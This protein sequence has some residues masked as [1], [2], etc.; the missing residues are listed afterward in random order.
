MPNSY[1]VTYKMPTNQSYHF[2]TTSAEYYIII[3]TS[4]DDHKDKTPGTVDLSKQAS[5]VEVVN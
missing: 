5:Y 4:N 3:D 2:S 1:S